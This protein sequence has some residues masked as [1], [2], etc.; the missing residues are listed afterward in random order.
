MVV[1]DP[2]ACRGPSLSPNVE[3]VV[4]PE[5]FE[6]Q[7]DL[8]ARR[9]DDQASSEAGQPSV[10]A[11]ERLGPRGVHEGH[12]SDVEVKFA[13][14][15]VQCPRYRVFECWRGADI[16]FTGHVERLFR[17]VPAELE[18]QEVIGHLGSAVGRA[19]ALSSHAHASNPFRK[20]QFGHEW[21]RT[22]SR[23]EPA[24]RTSRP[25]ARGA[26]SRALREEMMVAPPAVLLNHPIGCFGRLN[27]GACS[28]HGRKHPGRPG[29]RL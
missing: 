8:P 28:V 27:G 21:F 15:P 5:D 26:R 14:L 4:E 13:A 25:R 16:E 3:D 22:S 12:A 20:V 19:C 7:E 9:D 29:Q 11:Q 6:D 2:G 10:E 17:A 24:A 1:H 18:S 23:S